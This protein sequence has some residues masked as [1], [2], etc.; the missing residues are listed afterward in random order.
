M[1]TIIQENLS[2]PTAQRQLDAQK[3]ERFEVLEGLRKAV[4]E[5]HQV[6]LIGK[7]GSGKSTALRRLLWEEA[8]KSLELVES[9]QDNF[10][11]PV[12]IEL[13]RYSGGSVPEWIEEE[14]Q[15]DVS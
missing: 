11:I 5:H 3:H 6:L 4:R 1:Q 9:G 12:L 7:P 2:E 14:L 8:Q 13:R 10:T 15:I